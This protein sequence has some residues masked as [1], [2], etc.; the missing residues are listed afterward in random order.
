MTPPM[1]R[2]YYSLLVVVSILF[3]IGRVVE[4]FEMFNES[5]SKRNN[6]FKQYVLRRKGAF[7][8][9]I[10][11]RSFYISATVLMIMTL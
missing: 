5:M 2:I 11:A 1:K 7:R 4:F 10:K 6:M 9:H 8:Y 3:T